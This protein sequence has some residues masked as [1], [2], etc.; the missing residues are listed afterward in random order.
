ML[1][2][3]LA[4]THFILQIL[5]AVRA[6]AGLRMSCQPILILELMENSDLEWDLLLDVYVGL[7]R[8]CAGRTGLAIFTVTAVI[9]EIRLRIASEFVMGQ[10]RLDNIHAV[11][12]FGDFFFAKNKMEQ[13]AR[14]CLW[15]RKVSSECREKMQAQHFICSANLPNEFQTE[16][17]NFML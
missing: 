17:Y 2:W 9:A 13:H 12:R 10:R 6:K 7:S 11:Y 1:P 3:G 16:G 8:P 14:K 5:A 4:V 15:G